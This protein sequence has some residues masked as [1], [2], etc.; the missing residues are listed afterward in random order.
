MT[1]PHDLTVILYAPIYDT[2]VGP[3]S[4]GTTVLVV[5]ASPFS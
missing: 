5:I 1:E 4:L 2:H 3:C